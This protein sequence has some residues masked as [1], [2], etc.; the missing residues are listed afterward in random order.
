MMEEEIC[1]MM[2][3]LAESEKVLVGLG[4]EWGTE[5]GPEVKKAYEILYRMIG[6]RDYFIV[7]TVTDGAIFESRLDPERITA[8]C[9]NI[10]WL[11]CVNACTKDIWEEGERSDGTCPHCGELL[12]VN[13]IEQKNYIEEGYLPQW[14]AYTAWLTTTL[15]R[16]LTVLELGV[17][18]EVPTVIRWPFEKIIFYNKKSHLY[19]V[20]E[21][22]SQKTEEIRDR[23]TAIEADSVEYL[24]K[25]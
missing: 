20:N 15:N 6:D 22:F 12:A 8:P 23:M 16:R 13:T 24:R 19:R 3:A 25:R 1:Q 11:Q 14:K 2:E 17:G 5:R 7:T 21:K 9:G 18:F 10:H 4:S